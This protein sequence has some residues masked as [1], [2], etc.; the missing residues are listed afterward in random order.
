M[1]KRTLNYYDTNADDFIKGTINA[2]VSSLY[3]QF[4]PLI[5]LNARI[6]DLGCGS[7]RDSKNFLDMGYAVEAVDGSKAL[8]V[9]ASEYIGKQVRCLM[10]QDLDYENRFDG[11]WACASL[12]HVPKCDMADVLS[13]VNRALVADGVL[14]ASYKYGSDERVDGERRFSD[15]TEDDVPELF[16]ER[17]WYN[18]RFWISADVREDRTVKWL[19]VVARKR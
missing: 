4:L 5:P 1:D 9:K 12:L 6:L 18:C 3:D 15:Y 13:R 10:F 11:V 8:C 19:N 16:P 17:D 7:G 2:D 14:Y